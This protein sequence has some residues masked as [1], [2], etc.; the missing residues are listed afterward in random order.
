MAS[1]HRFDR[2]RAEGLHLIRLTAPG[3]RDD[4]VAAE[5]HRSGLCGR[6]RRAHQHRPRAPG[7]VGRVRHVVAVAMA[8]KNRCGL[9]DLVRREAE[10]SGGEHAR[11]VR[12]EEQHGVAIGYLVV[13]R[14]QVAEHKQ[15]GAPGGPGS[16]AQAGWRSWGPGRPS[17]SPSR[18]DTPV[19]AENRG[20]GPG[21]SAEPLV[22]GGRLFQSRYPSRSSLPPCGPGPP[23]FD[24]LVTASRSKISFSRGPQTPVSCVVS[25]EKSPA[26][27]KPARRRSRCTHEVNND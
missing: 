9:G 15:V 8:D 25:G 24:A 26:R 13:R 2:H 7:H 3:D 5:P 4:L 22:P 19:P 18:S 6:D 27:R 10:R 14:A 17:T 11:I 1:E 21:C 16:G 23:T 20:F 12:I